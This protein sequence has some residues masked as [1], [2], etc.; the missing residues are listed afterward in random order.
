[1][2][3]GGRLW[4]VMT[5]VGLGAFTLSVGPAR[6][7]VVSDSLSLS[8]D[9]Y[10]EVPRST[11]GFLVYLDGFGSEVFNSDGGLSSSAELRMK[12]GLVLLPLT[13]TPFRGSYYWLT[14]E[15]PPEPGPYTVAYRSFNY[16]SPEG[17]ERTL[18]LTIIADAEP[19]TEWGTITATEYCGFR[20]TPNGQGAFYIGVSSQFT[21]SA[22]L[23]QFL[24][25]FLARWSLSG[26]NSTDLGLGPGWS[27]LEREYSATVS[28]NAEYYPDGLGKP[29]GAG[30]VVFEAVMA[31]DPERSVTLQDS[32]TL[33]CTTCDWRAA[34]APED[35]VTQWRQAWD[36]IGGT[37]NAPPVGTAGAA[38]TPQGAIASEDASGCALAKGR[39][40]QRGQLLWIL[41]LLFASRRRL[42][43]WRSG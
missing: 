9:W 4:R 10:T 39:T 2:R 20:D 42:R 41:G 6:A 43:R 8:K 5:A 13:A 7:I 14:W 27:P 23:E 37:T 22:Q 19:P 30:T 32:L 29:E 25:V 12:S 34:G 17:E 3:G 28:C 38:T 11:G 18:P 24:G 26:I 1:M 16:F 36:G 15:T 40:Q 31:G 21:A 33:T 35:K